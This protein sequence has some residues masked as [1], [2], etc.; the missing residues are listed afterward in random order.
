M[1][2]RSLI[3]LAAVSLILA[4][5]SHSYQID[6][7]ARDFKDGDTICLVSENHIG[8][9]M[10]QTVITN[11]TFHFTGETDSVC[12]CDA[13]LKHDPTSRVSFF[14]EAGHI[15]LELHQYPVLSRVSG[16]YINNSWQQLADSVSYLS[17]DMIRILQ[18]PSQDASEHAGNVQIVDS[19]H[20]RMVS[21]I[22]NTARRNRDN[23]L[24]QYIN[25][26]YKAPEF[27]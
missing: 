4:C 26:K 11:G 15:V 24:G 2:I 5:Q 20:K 10:K 6:G 18:N 16:T 19:L 17:Q 1:N 27:E 23:P 3:G 21:C 9:I 8:Q 13:Y 22:L 14:L 7:Y 12:L 25:E